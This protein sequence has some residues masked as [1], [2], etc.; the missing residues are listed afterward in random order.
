MST[1]DYSIIQLTVLYIG[2]TIMSKYLILLFIV[3]GQCFLR[4]PLALSIIRVDC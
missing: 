4:P 1:S 3:F 2:H